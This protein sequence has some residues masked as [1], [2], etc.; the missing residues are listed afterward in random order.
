MANEPSWL[1]KW[2]RSPRQDRRVLIDGKF[3]EKGPVH[4]PKPPVEEESQPVPEATMPVV[5]EVSDAEPEIAEVTGVEDIAGN[6][7][8]SS[9]DSET[10]STAVGKIPE[11]VFPP[12]EDEND[13]PF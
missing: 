1:K 3:V 5:K 12:V 4:Q 7:Q 2:Q 8:I 9:L 13:I 6:E 11:P 10:D